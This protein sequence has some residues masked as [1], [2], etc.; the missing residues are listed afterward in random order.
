M[1]F[2][3]DRIADRII[4]QEKKDFT[5]ENTEWHLDWCYLRHPMT[6]SYQ[7][8]T[9]KVKLKGTEVTLDIPASPTFIGIRQKDFNADISCEVSLTSG[10]AGITLYMDENHHY[11]L[12]LRKHLEGYEII[13]RLNIGDIKS[14]EKILNI[15]QCNHASLVIKSTP[16]HYHFYMQVDATETLLGSAQT[17]YLSSEIAGGFTGVLIGLY[18]TGDSQDSNATFTKFSCSYS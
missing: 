1:S 18:A 13:E 14:I 17:R 4:Q 2:E 5:F 9:D 7:L 11:D 3:T 8:D 6:E 15:G 10:E 12:A 16:T